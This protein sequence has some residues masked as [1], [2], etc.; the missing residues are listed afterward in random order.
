MPRYLYVEEGVFLG[1]SDVDPRGF[2]LAEQPDGS[3]RRVLGEDLAEIHRRFP[4][5]IQSTQKTRGWNE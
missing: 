2:L 1:G 4:N 5:F 3:W